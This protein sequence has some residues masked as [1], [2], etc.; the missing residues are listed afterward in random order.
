MAQFFEA[1]EAFIGENLIFFVNFFFIVFEML[2]EK[3][4]FKK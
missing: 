2:R 3:I 4:N 1:K